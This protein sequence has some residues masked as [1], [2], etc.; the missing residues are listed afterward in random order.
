MLKTQEN[1][2]IKIVAIEEVN[3]QEKR[4]QE[5]RMKDLFLLIENLAMQEEA[6]I[7]LIIECLYDVGMIN[8]INK[9]VKH[10]SANKIIKRFI[11]LPKPMARIVAWRWIRKNMPI[12]LTNW[13]GRKVR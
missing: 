4:F 10:P 12:K 11:S 8:L 3:P 7:K 13:L 5:Q 9:K 6:T 1:K 2:P